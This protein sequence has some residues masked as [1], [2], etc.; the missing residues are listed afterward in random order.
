MI[1]NDMLLVT[2][3]DIFFLSYH[4]SYVAGHTGSEAWSPVAGLRLSL[5]ASALAED[6]EAWVGACLRGPGGSTPFH[7][8][9]DGVALPAICKD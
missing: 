7:Q 9:P 2:L 5:D 4:F 6:T 3:I 8:V 1:C